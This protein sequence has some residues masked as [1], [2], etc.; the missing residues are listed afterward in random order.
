MVAD[1]LSGFL[2]PD[3]SA[4]LDLDSLE[5]LPTE[6]LSDRR[7]QRRSD[8]VWR[9]RWGPDWLYV[10]ILIEFQSTE[11]HYMALRVCS[12]LALLLQD[13]LRAGQISGGERLPPVLP[14]VLYNGATPWRASRELEDLIT[15]PP[16]GLEPYQPRIRYLL[17]DEGRYSDDELAGHEGNVAAA[18]FRL[19]KGWPPQALL[20]VLTSLAEW[21]QAPGQRELQRAFVEWLREVW[22]QPRMKLLAGVDWTRANNLLEV[23]GMLAE[24]IEA[25]TEQLLRQGL[26]QGLAAERQLLARMASRRFGADVA[27]HLETLLASVQDLELLNEVGETLVDRDDGAGF[28]QAVE[29]LLSGHDGPG[30]Q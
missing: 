17:M 19:E 8:I 21:L 28:L 25:W 2:P 1:L 4:A 16:A 23:K 14:I 3:W 20:E 12:Y 30:D 29:Q 10:V 22:S 13:L 27:A 11:D 9:V 5:P 7:R 6:L 15:P 26:E 24:R 18:L